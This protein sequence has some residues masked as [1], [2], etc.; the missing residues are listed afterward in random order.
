MSQKSWETSSVCLT[1]TEAPPVGSHTSLSEVSSFQ[2]Y[3][4]FCK[5]EFCVVTLAQVCKKVGTDKCLQSLVA[6]ENFW[7]GLGHQPP[8][9]PFFLDWVYIY[10]HELKTNKQTN[11]QLIGLLPSSSVT[12]LSW[13]WVLC[14]VYISLEAGRGLAIT[15][16]SS[17]IIFHVLA[18][19]SS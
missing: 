6:Y 18:L 1:H 4:C 16:F 3:D 7:R 15:L 9:S 5:V 10:W 8:S 17:E 14:L 2:N 19:T 11:R 13:A 12:W